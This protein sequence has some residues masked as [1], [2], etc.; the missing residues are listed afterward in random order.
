M[1]LERVSFNIALFLNKE[2]LLNIFVVSIFIFNPQVIRKKLFLNGPFYC[3]RCIV[4][5]GAD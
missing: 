2:K 3:F 4:H 5:Y 1:Q